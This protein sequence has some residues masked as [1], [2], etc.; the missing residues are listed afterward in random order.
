[1]GTKPSVSQKRVGTSRPP[2]IS[3]SVSPHHAS[4]THGADPIT[5]LGQAKTGP[6]AITSPGDGKD[7]SE[8]AGQFK[9][10]S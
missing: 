8:R 1:M 2:I 7:R 9:S 6:G 10:V 4:G 3:D 5:P